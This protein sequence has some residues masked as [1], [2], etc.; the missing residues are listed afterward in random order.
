MGLG[1]IRIEILKA[2]GIIP[3]AFLCGLN[4]AEVFRLGVS[5]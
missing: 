1:G 3:S 2:D 4:S 5:V